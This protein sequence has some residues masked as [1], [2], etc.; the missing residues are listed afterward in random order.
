MNI[1]FC[2][3]FVCG[4]RSVLVSLQYQLKC[5]GNQMFVFIN[6]RC[7]QDYATGDARV[8]ADDLFPMV[9]YVVMNSNLDDLNQRLGFLE[10]YIKEEV[11]FFGE[12]AICL[13]LLQGTFKKIRIISFTSILFEPPLHIFV[14]DRLKILN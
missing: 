7:A 13:T 3:L 1:F 2:S 9:V 4:H 8:T 11:K 6:L 5:C 10:R 12:P 14:N